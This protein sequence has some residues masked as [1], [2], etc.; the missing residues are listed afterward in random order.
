MFAQ[1]KAYV[2]IIFAVIG[3]A[4]LGAGLNLS[5]RALDILKKHH[6]GAGVNLNALADLGDFET[7]TYCI[8]GGTNGLAD[9]IKIFE[10][11][12]AVLES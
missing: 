2:N 4:A 9:R 7:I 10:R 3:L 6:L 5:L 1:I 12:Q 8:N 11:A